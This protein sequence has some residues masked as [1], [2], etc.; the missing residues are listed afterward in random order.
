MAATTQKPVAVATSTPTPTTPASVT[1]A[2]ISSAEPNPKKIVSSS[3]DKSDPPNA[4]GSL[5][6][7]GGSKTTGT[8]VGSV[9]G[10]ESGPVNDI[11][12]KIRRAERF[13]VPVQLSEQEKRNSRAERFGTAPRPKGSE[14]SKQ[15]EEVKRKARAE[16][17]GLAVP[18]T[19]VDE[20]EKRK[21]RLARFAPYSKPDT[22]EGEKRKA[23]A[24]RFSDPLST[25][26]AQVNHKGNIEPEA[27]VAGKAVGGL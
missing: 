6:E 15:S 14:A 18:S 4:E 11:Q 1:L 3:S 20:E 22:I 16:R 24:I 23:R 25:S 9:V 21:A 26:L 12:K 7:S 19:T 2:A 8:T 5:K 13:G 10:D 27:P 17:F